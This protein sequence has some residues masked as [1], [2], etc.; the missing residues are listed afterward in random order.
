MN[1]NYNDNRYRNR[2]KHTDSFSSVH[3]PGGFVAWPD[4]STSRIGERR[5]GHT[6]V[7]GKYVE[8]KGFVSWPIGQAQ[9]VRA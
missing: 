9:P 4:G 5:M 8:R 2:N 7:K 6:L 3:P 1:R